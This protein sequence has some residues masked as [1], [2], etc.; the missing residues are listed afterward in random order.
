VLSVPVPEDV[1]GVEV[2]WKILEIL[3]REHGAKV[4]DM[5]LGPDVMSVEVEI[6]GPP[7]AA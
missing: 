5:S 6:Q 3:S 7:P 1:A 4:T 2:M